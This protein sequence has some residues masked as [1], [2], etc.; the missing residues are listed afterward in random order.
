VRLRSIFLVR[1]L[2]SLRVRLIYL[3]VRTDLQGV[4]ATFGV[5]PLLAEG[6]FLSVAFL[7]VIYL[8]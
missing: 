2:L 6:L 1:L 8:V 7:I 3:A 4:L 5:M